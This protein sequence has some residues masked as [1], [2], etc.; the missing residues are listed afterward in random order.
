LE[1]KKKEGSVA[2]GSCNAIADSSTCLEF[3]GSIWTEQHARLNCADMGT[4]STSPCPSGSFGGCNVGTGLQNDMVTWFYM[5]GG[6]EFND[7]SAQNAQNAC[8]ANPLGRW[9]TSK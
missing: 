4:F 5:E 1:D 9:I 3:Y 7:R 2:R 8:N 6:G